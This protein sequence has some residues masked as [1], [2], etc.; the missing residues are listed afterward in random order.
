MG[1]EGTDLQLGLARILLQ[2]GM[3]VSSMPIGVEVDAFLL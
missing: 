3:K 1:D 2:V